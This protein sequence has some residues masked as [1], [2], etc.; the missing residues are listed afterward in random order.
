AIEIAR[1]PNE[2][3]TNLIN[4]LLDQLQAKTKAV[5]ELAEQRNREGKEPMLQGLFPEPAP[6]RETQMRQQANE[7]WLA[8]HRALLRRVRAGTPPNPAEVLAQLEGMR[9][10]ELSQ[11]QARGIEVDETETQKIKDTLV[12]AR[13]NIYQNRATGITVYAGPDVFT[14]VNAWT[15]PQLPGIPLI[16]DWQMR[17]WV[18]EELMEAVAAANSDPNLGALSVPQAPIKRVLNMATPAWVL[19]GMTTTA[20]SGNFTTPVSANF[21]AS[22]TGRAA[23]PTANNPVF[24]IRYA[25]V[26]LIV[27]TKRIPLVLDAFSTSNFMSVLDMDLSAVDVAAHHREGY[28]YGGDHVMR[29]DLVIETIWLRSWTKEFMPPAVKAALGVPAPPPGQQTEEE[30]PQDEPQRD[31]SRRERR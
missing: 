28:D 25:T 31:S 19:E 17:Y 23:F 18:H 1:P 15:D 27:D 7:A 24:D 2:A 14:D 4:S 11:L 5:Y 8:A 20:L 30:A 26:S 21:N 22:V 6:G 3:T 10:T 13:Q 16:W 9:E 12:A 29:A